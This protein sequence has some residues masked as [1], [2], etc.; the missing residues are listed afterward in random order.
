MN[1]KVGQV[2]SPTY[3]VVGNVIQPENLMKVSSS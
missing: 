1:G 2:E 3:F